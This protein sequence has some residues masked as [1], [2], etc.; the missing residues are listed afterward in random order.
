VALLLGGQREGLDPERHV[1]LPVGQQLVHGAHAVVD[2]LGGALQVL[3][4]QLDPGVV[5]G[6]EVDHPALPGSLPEALPHAV[7]EIQGVEPELE[8]DI[9]L[10]S[11]TPSLTATEEGYIVILR[12]TK[13]G[14]A[15]EPEVLS[16]RPAN[17]SG[18]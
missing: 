13:F 1:P 10:G 5:P 17:R 3:A 11:A 2:P 9:L 14:D 7:P 4:R 12:T 16:A 6:G 8:D 18:P 15:H